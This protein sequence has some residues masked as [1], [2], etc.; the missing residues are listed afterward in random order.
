MFT[1]VNENCELTVHMTDR[2]AV[3][4]NRPSVRKQSWK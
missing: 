3:V 1:H 2:D 4:L